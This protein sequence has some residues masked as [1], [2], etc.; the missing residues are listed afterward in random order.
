MAEAQDHPLVVMKAANGYI[1][2]KRNDPTSLAAANS[3][4]VFE[5][6]NGALEHIRKH[7]E[8]Q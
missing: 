8:G 3:E 7:F 2:T 4:Y 6:M 5:S 1:V